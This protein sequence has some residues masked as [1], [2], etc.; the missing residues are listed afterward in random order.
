MKYISLVLASFI[1]FISNAQIATLQAIPGTKLSM[2]PPKGFVKANGFDGFQNQL[3]Q[4]SIMVVE[5]PAPIKA[6]I[7]G[8]NAEDLKKKGMV[9]VDKKTMNHQGMEAIML[10]VYQYGNGTT[11]HKKMLIFGD[12]KKSLMINCIYPEA[13]KQIEDEMT[14]SLQSVIYTENQKT[15]EVDAATFTMDTKGTGLQFTNYLS[16]SLSY[17]AD[18]KITSDTVD[19]F[20]GPSVGTVIVNDKREYT[21]ERLK[22]LPRGESIEIKETNPIKIDGLEGFEIVGQGLDKNGNPN[23]IY[24]VMLYTSDSINSN[25]F[26]L[27]GRTSTH[28]EKWLSTFRQFAKT[29]H[30]K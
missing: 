29:F 8:F 2:I 24:H 3:L 4:A 21:I 9:L 23:L 6:S 22:K 10:N 28:R 20:A 7:A 13:S 25:Y 26:I 27:G 12:S 19:F 14:R 18:P 11:Y 15:N 16:G 30:Q 1:A 5:L 17:A